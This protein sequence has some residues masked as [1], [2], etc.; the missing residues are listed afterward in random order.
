MEPPVRAGH[1]EEL[2]FWKRQQWAVAGYAIALIAGGFHI[3][4]SLMPP[5][6]PWEKGTASVL[7]VVIGAGAGWLIWDLQESLK[8][9]RLILDR[10][11]KDPF[12]RGIRVVYG[13]WAALLIS[14]VAVV[15]SLWRSQA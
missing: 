8:E 7:I 4:Q 5:L 14:A 15:Y 12:W 2:R 6:R 13:L 1:M 11:D 10:E 9:T 3:A